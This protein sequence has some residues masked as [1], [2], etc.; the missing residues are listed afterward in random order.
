MGYCTVV[1][2]VPIPEKGK[3]GKRGIS[4]ASFPRRKRIPRKR[5][6]SCGCFEMVE[7]KVR[8]RKSEKENVVLPRHFAWGEKA[9]QHRIEAGYISDGKVRVRRG[10]G[11][12]N[13]SSHRRYA[14]QAQ[15]R[16]GK[17]TL[18][19]EMQRE[20]GGRTGKRKIETRVACH[21]CAGRE[22]SPQQTLKGGSCWGK[23]NGGEGTM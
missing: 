8:R 14:T 4:P 23:A 15:S 3:G 17:R 12:E 6:Q 19:L 18:N 13:E 2:A 21:N 1:A 10:R 22:S 20:S 7:Q 5:A 11:G 16:P 9:F